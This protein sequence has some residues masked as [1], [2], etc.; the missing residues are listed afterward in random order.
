MFEFS[1][2]LLVY[3]IWFFFLHSR[4]HIEPWFIKLAYSFLY[5]N[6]SDSFLYLQ[7]WYIPS[8]EVSGRFWLLC[9]S[10]CWD[11][12]SAIFGQNLMYFCV[13]MIFLIWIWYIL[14]WIIQMVLTGKRSMRSYQRSSRSVIK[15]Y[16]ADRLGI[17]TTR[18][19][20]SVRRYGKI[21]SID[22]WLL[23]SVLFRTFLSM[24]GIWWASIACEH[25]WFLIMPNM[26]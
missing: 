19:T 24:K 17:K 1:K 11:F 22:E 6:H 21:V 15:S 16:T 5:Y 20:T 13:A 23:L 2:L 3:C 14:I 9:H 10:R 8:D 12:I 26:L 7:L 18:T 4:F 25:G